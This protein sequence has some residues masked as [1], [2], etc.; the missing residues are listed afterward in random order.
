MNEFII[1]LFNVVKIFLY[2]R[3]RIMSQLIHFFFELQTNV[4]L[5]HWM[6]LSYARHKA[7]GETYA[8]LGDL[9]DRF[10]EVCMG[11]HGRVELQQGT[12]IELMNLDEVKPTEF[13]AATTEMLIAGCSCLDAKMDSDLLNIRDE[14]LAEINKLK[15]LLTLQ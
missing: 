7:F 5:Y 15:Y 2:N 13:C 6:T 12:C 10:A 8:A 11:K 9:I 4:K 1:H 3:I 14:M